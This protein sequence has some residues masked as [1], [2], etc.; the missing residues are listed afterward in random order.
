M[1]ASPGDPVRRKSRSMPNAESF[2]QRALIVFVQLKRPWLPREKLN[3]RI[4][5]IAGRLNGS[6]VELKDRQYL[7]ANRL[8]PIC[9]SI[10][11]S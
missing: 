4:A 11:M 3:V 7:P 5:K 6:V 8:L 10:F 1:P 2:T 9:W